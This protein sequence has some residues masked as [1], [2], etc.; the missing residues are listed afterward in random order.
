MGG[1]KIQVKV[2]L[3]DFPVGYEMCGVKEKKSLFQKDFQNSL[4]EYE[5]I[6]VLI[7]LQR[8]LGSTKASYRRCIYIRFKYIY[9][10]IHIQE[11]PSWLSG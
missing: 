3:K 11:F 5:F 6:Y 1:G 7:T 2:I 8:T 10:K 4:S 9:I